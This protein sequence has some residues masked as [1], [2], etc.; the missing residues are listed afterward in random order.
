MVVL[1][2]LVSQP[3]PGQ[4]KRGGEERIFAA[5]ARRNYLP[6]VLHAHCSTVRIKK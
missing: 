1:L 2:L 4:I 6:H 5:F 3:E